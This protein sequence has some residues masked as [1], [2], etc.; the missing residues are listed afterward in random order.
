MS[1][2]APNEILDAVLGSITPMLAAAGYKKSARRFIALGDGVARVVQFPTSQL[3]KPDEANFTLSII[4]TSI[5]FHEAFAGTP[6]P[7]N[8]ASAE[9]VVQAGVGRLMPDGENIAWSLKP[10]VSSALIAKEIE[11]LLKDPVLPFLA[12]FGSEAAL[13]EELQHG[14]TLPGFGAMRERCRAVL[15]ARRGRKDEAGKALAALLQANSAEGL[16]G[17]RDSVNALARHL[18]VTP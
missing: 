17:F 6:F 13:L 12:R 3:K 10:G 9:A 18:G 11:A 8:A 1:D 2:Q 16:E 4:V 5:A 14:E 7:K 15:L